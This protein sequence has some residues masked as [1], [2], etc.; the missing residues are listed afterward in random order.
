MQAF[1]TSSPCPSSW[2]SPV[3]SP[4][5]VDDI[6]YFGSG[7]E[8]LAVDINTREEQWRFQAADTIE[9]SPAVM[10]DAVITGSN[11]GA[12]YAVDRATGNRLWSVATGGS[13]M[14]KTLL[15]H[16][17]HLG[18]MSLEDMRPLWGATPDN[19]MQ[20]E[21]ALRSGGVEGFIV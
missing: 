18:E 11:D 10:D 2:V 3:S 16:A 13:I 12:L 9:S 17:A 14:V 4:A 15:T 19:P 7:S 6:L 5:L 20:Y 1:I 8:L 21:A